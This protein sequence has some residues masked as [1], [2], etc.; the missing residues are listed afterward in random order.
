VGSSRDVG[1]PRTSVEGLQPRM[2]QRAIAV[3]LS[4]FQ[5]CRGWEEGR[6]V[7]SVGGRNRTGS[8]RDVGVLEPQRRVSGLGRSNGSRSESFPGT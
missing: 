2:I 8:S 5:G 6:G 7:G 3:V 4:G 1:V